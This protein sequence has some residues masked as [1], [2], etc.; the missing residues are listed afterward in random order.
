MK[1]LLIVLSAVLLS[2]CRDGIPKK[3]PSD[4]WLQEEANLINWEQ[5]DVFPVFAT[6]GEMLPL[7]AQKKC[8]QET[9]TAHLH[10]FL[11]EKFQAYQNYQD[12]IV[13]HIEVD[14]LGQIKI[15]TLQTHD[16]HNILDS[17]I[18]ESV[19]DLPKIYPAL[20]RNIPVNTQLRMALILQVE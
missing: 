8:F 3:I 7:D 10:A 20:K 9:L 18:Q 15:N 16:A 1:I 6:C 2:A 5:V 19:I 12:T 11:T 4:T 14:T 13:L 17:L